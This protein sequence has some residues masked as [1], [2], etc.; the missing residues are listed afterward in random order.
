MNLHST[1]M[2][3]NSIA[4]RYSYQVDY[5]E[6]MTDFMESVASKSVIPHQVEIQPGRLSGK[7]LCWMTCAY[8]YGGSSQNTT[9]KLSPERYI[10]LMNQLASGPNGGIK[11]VVFAGYATDPLNYEYIDDLVECALKNGQINGFNTKALRVSDR[12]VKL[13][14]DKNTVEKCYFNVSVD[15][16]SAKIY[17]DVHSINSKKD[18]YHKILENISRITSAIKLSGV[19]RD[20][21]ASYLITHQ[22]NSPAEIEAAVRDISDAGVNL[23]RF[24]FPQV[25]R[26]M[27]SA[28]GSSIPTK[29]EAGAY[30]NKLAPLIES[31]DSAETRV[32]I[33]NTDAKFDN[34]PRRVLPCLARFVFPTIGYDG[35]M[36]HCSQ[37]AAPHF[38]ELSLGNLQKIDFWDAYYNYDTEKIWLEMEKFTYKTMEK[39]DCRCDRK[40][41][42]VNTLFKNHLTENGK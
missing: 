28:E 35:Y 25:P 1:L 17:N 14:A 40:E 38:R 29:T 26:G 37:S 32:I 12:L 5:I 42:C 22:N 34:V 9:E 15:A 16:G 2:P 27:T 36:Y 24:T 11:K 7:N 23:I 39:L 31:L 18:I 10:D 33:L 6:D 30:H 21:S 13:L 4:D 19:K 8:C 3:N 20:V 41:Q